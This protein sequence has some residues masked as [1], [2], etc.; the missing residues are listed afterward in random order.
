MFTS[1][2]SETNISAAVNTIL[3]RNSIDEHKYREFTDRLKQ[4]GCVGF[5]WKENYVNFKI[6]GSTGIIGDYSTGWFYLKYSELPD[7]VDRYGDGEFFKLS[8]K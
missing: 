4:L 5:E 7:L 8:D 2:Y 1:K 6:K 3:E